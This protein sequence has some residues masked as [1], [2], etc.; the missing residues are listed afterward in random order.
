MWHC[1]YHVVWT[2]KYRMRI[3]EG[4]VGQ[5]VASCV[6]AFSEQK[7][8]NIIELNVQRDHVHLVVMVPPKLSISDY[9][10]IIKGRTAIGIFNK[11]RDLKKKPYW[12]NHFWSRGYCVDT[13]GLDAEK[14]C[15]YVKY[16]EDKERQSDSRQQQLF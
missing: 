5:E 15:R 11:F 14:I 9:M 1:Q 8:C 2:P 3:L 12:G 7:S 16:Q 4:A 13:V 6:R 10:G